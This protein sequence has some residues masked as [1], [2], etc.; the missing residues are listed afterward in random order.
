MGVVAYKQPR[1]GEGKV[2][3][4]RERDI[5]TRLQSLLNRKAFTENIGIKCFKKKDHYNKTNVT[6][7]NI[8]GEQ[9][10]RVWKKCD[11]WQYCQVAV[12]TGGFFYFIFL[13]VLVD[14]FLKKV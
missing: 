4:E 9:F 11:T 6:D 5:R 3:R 1:E 12:F 14:F 13:L 8:K 2:E 7:D 10:V